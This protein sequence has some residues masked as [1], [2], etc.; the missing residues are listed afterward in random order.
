MDDG[1]WSTV[2]AE[3]LDEHWWR[4]ATPMCFRCATPID[5]LQHY[6]HNCH[7]AVGQLTPFIPFVNIP[8]ACE[9][10]CRMWERLWQRN[11]ESI[12]RRI[13]YVGLLLIGGMVSGYFWILP[14]ALV[15]WWRRPPSRPGHCQACDYD[16]RGT[17]ERCPECGASISASTSFTRR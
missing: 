5:R 12:A 17:D 11:G 3:D 10:F 15:C 4:D 1:E 14:I 8:L 2:D 13:T 16:L 7:A 6:C 9:P